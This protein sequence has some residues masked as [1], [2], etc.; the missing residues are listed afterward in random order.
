MQSSNLSTYHNFTFEFNLAEVR[1]NDNAEIR[2]IHV[3][4]PV[5]LKIT[6]C[7]DDCWVST[8]PFDCLQSTYSRTNIPGKKSQNLMAS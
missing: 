4:V 7:F 1:K 3:A 6:H 8:V 5:Y 2:I